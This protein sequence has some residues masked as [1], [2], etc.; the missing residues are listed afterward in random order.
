LGPNPALVTS[1]AVKT[2]E[3]APQAVSVKN[4]GL[5]SAFLFNPSNSLSSLASSLG[6]PQ[7]NLT[8]TLLSFARAFSLPL[9]SMRLVELRREVLAFVS[10]SPKTDREKARAEAFSLASIAAEAKGFKLSQ[11]ALGEYVA[12]MGDFFEGGSG[13]EGGSRQENDQ[14]QQ[15]ENDHRGEPQVQPPNPAEL[16]ESFDKFSENDGLLGLMNAALKKNRRNW[17][18]WPFKMCVG[19][20]DLK[21]FVRILIEEPFS[22]AGSGLLMAD[23]TGPKRHWRFFLEKSPEGKFRARIG[24][25]PGHEPSGLKALEIEAVKALGSFFTDV[26]VL[27]GEIMLADFLG[28]EALPSI[29]EEV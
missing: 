6:L 19:G 1:N 3:S 15:E 9:E 28:C 14:H 5:S 20:T 7:D 22:F 29:N 23:I 25:V 10:S 8:F 12:A 16:R 4:A 27:N 26:Q 11:E 18:V 17:V 13:E 24:L 2:A 21:I